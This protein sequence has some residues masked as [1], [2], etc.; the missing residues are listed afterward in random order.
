M[1]LKL[2]IKKE[3]IKTLMLPIAMIGG[4]V[5]YKWLGYLT[6]L[7]PFLIFMMLFIMLK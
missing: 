6:F 3:K 4:A 2:A 1:H 7:S 5:F